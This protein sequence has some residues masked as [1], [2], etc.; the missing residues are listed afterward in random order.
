MA[1]ELRN[2]LGADLG[3]DRPLPATLVFDYPTIDAIVNYVASEAFGGNGSAFDGDGMQELIGRQLEGL[4][5]DEAEAMLL[6]E[7]AAIDEDG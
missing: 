7:L 1:V 2:V 5:E 3:L 4:S 6:E